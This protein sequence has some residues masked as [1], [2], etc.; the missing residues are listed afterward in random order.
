MKQSIQFRFTSPSHHQPCCQQALRSACKPDRCQVQHMAVD[1]MPLS[2]RTADSKVATDFV[3]AVTTAWI[4]KGTSFLPLV[5]GVCSP[6]EWRERCPGVQPPHC[7]C[8]TQRKRRVDPGSGTSDLR[9][10]SPGSQVRQRL[11]TNARLSCVFRI[12]SN[13]PTRTA[14][15]RYFLIPDQAPTSPGPGEMDN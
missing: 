1:G 9:F 12:S 11:R 3:S 2:H 15:A 4:Q 6:G 10:P 7:R 13:T 14:S 8:C 5:S